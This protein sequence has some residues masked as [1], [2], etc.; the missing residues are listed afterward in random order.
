MAEA[1]TSLDKLLAVSNLLQRADLSPAARLVGCYLVDCYNKDSGQCNPGIDRIEAS[2]GLKKT[3]VYEALNELIK[4]GLLE[5]DTGRRNL[6]L[7]KYRPIF[8]QGSRDNSAAIP[9]ERKQRFRSS[10]NRTDNFRSAGN[11]IPPERNEVSARAESSVRPSGLEPLKEPVKEP[12]AREG[13]SAGPSRGLGAAGQQGGEPTEISLLN[14]RGS[15]RLAL[16][17]FLEPKVKFAIKQ[18][19][20]SDLELIAREL[21]ALPPQHRVKWDLYSTGEFVRQRVVDLATERQ[22][23]ADQQA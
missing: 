1:I 20:E 2:L 17:G 4:A 11:R 8:L 6:N 5:R 22:A 3:R 23:E 16:K 19:V 21:A 18:L 10:G 15:V 13:G 12:R 7:A 14:A 9:P